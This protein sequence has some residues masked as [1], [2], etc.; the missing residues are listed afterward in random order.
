VDIATGD[1]DVLSVA[2]VGNAVHGTV[3]MVEGRI[4]FIPD[5]DFNGLA[6]FDYTVSDGMGGR[7]N[8]TT[9]IRIAAV[10][11]A[12]VGVG[13]RIDIDEDTIAVIPQ[14]VLL[15]NE[16]DPD[17]ATN[18][19]TLKIISFSNA[20]HGT[21]FFNDENEV[22]FV[23][24]ANYHG[25]A[26]FDYTVRDE[27]GVET[28]AHTTV[29]I[30][31]VNDAPV[32]VG[33]T[34]HGGLA[35][36]VVYIPV[37]AVLQNDYD[38]DGDPVRL[39]GILSTEH[40]EAVVDWENSGSS[41]RRRRT[42]RARQAS[43]IRSP[44]IRRDVRGGDGH[45]DQ[46]AAGSAARRDH[47]AG[48]RRRPW[49]TTSRGRRSI[50]PETLLANDSDVDGDTL[51]IRWVGNSENCTVEIQDDGTIRLTTPQNYN[52]PASFQYETTDGY[53]GTAVQS[54]SVNVLAVNDRPVIE[55]VAQ[56]F[57]IYCYEYK[58]SEI[59]GYRYEEFNP[60][61]IPVYSN[62]SWTVIYDNEKAIQVYREGRA[63]AASGSEDPITPSFYRNGALVPI[64]YDKNEP[65][66]SADDEL[67]DTF[68]KDFG[69][70]VAWDPDGNSESLSYQ[71][72]AHPLHGN[73]SL[74]ALRVIRVYRPE[75]RGET[76]SQGEVVFWEINP[77]SYDTYFGN[78]NFTVRVA[79][80]GCLRRCSGDFISLGLQSGGVSR[81]HRHRPR[82]AGVRR[83]GTIQTCSTTSTGT[84]GTRTSPGPTRT[85]GSSPSTRTATASSTGTTRS[86]SPA[87]R[88]EPERTSKACR[89]S[90]PT[91][92]AGLPRTTPTGQGS[93]SGRT[94]TW[95]V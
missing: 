89:L 85:T 94:R 43:G 95:T 50:L 1:G 82:P 51:T 40:G 93:A 39:T 9:S 19:D 38:V 48:G 21:V 56:G 74:A 10:N 25:T 84:A 76:D 7:T 42:S 31:S 5:A 83:R 22:V 53:G 20:S 91:A 49:I 36:A 46:H 30:A 45:P 58:P 37:S 69:H 32:A 41:S 70:I 15:A 2:S 88:K 78:S 12:P 71:I 73:A 55:G 81:R 8:G 24:D 64:A 6:S 13:E 87:T 63:V 4:E 14:S 80:G 77:T 47:G 34:F 65:L 16:I 27:A 72:V 60:V 54:V 29:D 3:R 92:T 44:T 57:P 67:K 35:N 75:I 11:D 62:P 66:L 23:P 79:M 86:R 61:P 26:G 28:T 59:I 17:I 90:I 18:G 68:T 52:G 33:E